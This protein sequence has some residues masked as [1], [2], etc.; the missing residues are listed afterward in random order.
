[1]PKAQT[2]T[3]QVVRNEGAAKSPCDDAHLEHLPGLQPAG[4]CP[5]GALG[6]SPKNQQ[7]WGLWANLEDGEREMKNGMEW[8]GL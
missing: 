4:H 8:D 3:W 7:V 5:G 2:M 6:P 1:M